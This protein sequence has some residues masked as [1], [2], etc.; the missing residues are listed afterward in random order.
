MKLLE[1][2]VVVLPWDPTAGIGDGNRETMVLRHLRM[3][4]QAALL[5]R[6]FKCV[7]NQIQKDLL[8]LMPISP[9]RHVNQLLGLHRNALLFRQWM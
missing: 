4:D 3:H 6:E 1:D 2:F 8:E 9:Y 5:W 7:M